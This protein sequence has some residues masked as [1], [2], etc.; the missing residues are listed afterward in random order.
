MGSADRVRNPP[1][2]ISRQSWQVAGRS[3][4]AESYSTCMGFCDRGR[5]NGVFSPLHWPPG[6]D[7]LGGEV[8]QNCFRSRLRATVGTRTLRKIFRNTPQDHSLQSKLPRKNFGDVQALK[9]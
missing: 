6:T 4:R 8:R 3:P 1:T 5:T 9:D 2:K 7:R